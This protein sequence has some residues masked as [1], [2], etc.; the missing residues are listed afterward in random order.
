MRYPTEDLPPL[1]AQGSWTTVA[2]TRVGVA[3]GAIKSRDCKDVAVLVAPGITA[4]VITISTAAA[5]PCHYT[6]KLLPGY[7]TAVVV[8]SGNANAS[9]GEQGVSDTRQMA[10]R[11]AQVLNVPPAQVLV[12]STGVI[13]QPLPMDRLLPAIGRAAS[14]LSAD[15]TDAAQAIMTTDTFAKE[16]ACTV[17]A[18]TV[19]GISKGSGMIHPN[20]ATML[21]FLSTDVKVAPNP[22]QEL[23]S[24]IADSTFNAITVDGDMSTNDCLIIQSTGQGVEAEPGTPA[25]DD[26]V[27]ATYTVCRH[28]AREIARDGEGAEHLIECVVEGLPTEHA[29]RVARDVLRS[30]LVKTAIHGRDANWGRIVGALGAVGVGDLDRLDLDMAGIPVLRRGCPVAVD[31]DAATEALSAAEVQIHI[32]L[33]GEGVGRA[34][35]C[36]LSAGY[37]RINADYR[38]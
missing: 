4:G 9:T 37:V 25:W 8:N 28:L 6:R 33:P 35:G 1:V 23:I 10:F 3:G 5:A 32:R 16:A 11:A 26:L 14:D 34:W 18:V 38:S 15:G 20:M 31:E 12:C 27:S 36:D 17:G 2:G 21:G 22:L 24:E 30:P 19:G 29:R 7:A 13:G